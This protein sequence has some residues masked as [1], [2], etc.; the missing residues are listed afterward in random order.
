[1]LKTLPQ[2]SFN[3]GCDMTP[4]RRKRISRTD[5]CSLI[6]N[7]SGKKGYSYSSLFLLLP[8]LWVVLM[9]QMPPR[10][11]K[12]MTKYK[13]SWKVERPWFLMKTLSCSIFGFLKQNPF[14]TDRLRYLWE[15]TTRMRRH[16]FILSWR[17]YL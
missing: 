12:H 15:E 1:M 16:S 7:V 2:Y 6:N 4:M 9:L 3:C 5:F 8:A 13:R 17:Y 14:L 10:G 11:R